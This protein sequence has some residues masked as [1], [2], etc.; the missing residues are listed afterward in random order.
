MYKKH[1]TKKIKDM[2]FEDLKFLNVIN[3]LET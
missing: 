3:I 1:K 2:E